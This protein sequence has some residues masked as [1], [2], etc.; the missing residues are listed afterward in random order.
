V[1]RTIDDFLKA[2]GTLT[3]GTLKVL[4]RVTDETIDQAVGEGHRTLAHLGWHIVTTVP[5]MM[6]LTGLPLSAVDPESPP[7]QTAAEITSGYK[8]V[9]AELI[10]TIKANWND[11]SMTVTDDMYGQKWPRGGSLAALVNHEIHHRGQMTVL[12]RQAGCKVPGLMGPA[13][14]EWSQYGKPT[15]PY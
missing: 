7:P 15:P 10:D 6:K 1:F 12:L 3:E 14:E 13:K 4:E 2:Y 5:E 8:L 9:T 11:D